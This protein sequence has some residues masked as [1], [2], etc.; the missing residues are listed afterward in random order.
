MLPVH[1]RI[2]SAHEQQLQ[3]PASADQPSQTTKSNTEV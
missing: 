3:G 1:G 2:N